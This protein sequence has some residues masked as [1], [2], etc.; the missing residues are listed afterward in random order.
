MK[1][2]VCKL[3]EYRLAAGLTQEELADRV[4]ARRETIVRLEAGRFNPSLR[5]AFDA[6]RAVGAPIEDIFLLGER[7]GDMPIREYHFARRAEVEAAAGTGEAVRELPIGRVEEKRGEPRFYFLGRFQD[8][9]AVL[10]FARTRPHLGIYDERGALCDPEAVAAE[11]RGMK[12]GSGR[13]GSRVSGCGAPYS[14]LKPA[15]E[16]EPGRCV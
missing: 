4:G 14:D 1:P 16:V 15:Q 2:F 13:A 5:L 9:A 8:A 10:E 11:L 6:A 12:L 7:R 3:R